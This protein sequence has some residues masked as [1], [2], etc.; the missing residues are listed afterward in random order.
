MPQRVAA[1]AL[2]E[3]R[4]LR[5]ARDRTLYHGLMQVEPRRRAPL[6]ITTNAP[7]RKDKLP[8]PLSWRVRLLPLER[9]REY[10]S[11]KPLGEVGVMLTPD[12]VKMLSQTVDD[13][14]RQH[15]AA[16]LLALPAA[17]HDFAPVEID[18]LHTKLQ[19][20]LQT[21][22]CTVEQHGHQPRR[23]GKRG[24]DGPDLRD[25]QY[26]RDSHRHSRARRLL[27]DSQVDVQQIAIQK[28]H[29]ATR[30]ILRQADTRRSTASHFTKAE[31]SADPS[32]VGCRL[33]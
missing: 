30:L 10:H 13:R 8:T 32:S 26:H 15:H 22:A 24:Q 4:S 7:G 5:R 16:I 14:I 12:A 21:Q 31:T 3:S 27:D 17:N 23:A 18:V 33:P 29:S 20:L 6:R 2:G 25:A 9:S 28:K 1:D 11:A 19:A